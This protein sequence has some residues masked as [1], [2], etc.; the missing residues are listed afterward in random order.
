MQTNTIL[1]DQKSSNGREVVE[2]EFG[3]AL[4][5]LRKDR[6]YSQEEL[7]ARSNLHRT[8]ISL[9]ERGQKSPSLTTICRVANALD[10]KPHEL[11]SVAEEL[12]KQEE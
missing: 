7:A 2:R 3:K 5:M 8:Y 9:L 11:I 12:I 4:K 10:V 1:Y 6:G